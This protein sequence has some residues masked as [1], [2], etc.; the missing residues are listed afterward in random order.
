MTEAKYLEWKKFF[1]E[2]LTFSDSESKLKSLT[3]SLPSIYQ[4]AIGIFS[5]QLQEVKELSLVKDEIYGKLFSKYKKDH[6]RSFS[7]KEIDIMIKSED[8]YIDVCIEYNKQETYLKYLE[9]TIDNIKK[10]SFQVKNFIEIKK[11]YQGDAY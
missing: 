3:R 6:S 5:E 7:T 8:K 10:I 4:S 1:N 9:A 2:T 11:F